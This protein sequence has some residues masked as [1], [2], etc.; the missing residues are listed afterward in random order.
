MYGLACGISIGVGVGITFGVAL[1]NIAIGISTG[2]TP[3]GLMG[4]SWYK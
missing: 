2:F 3:Y 4:R 1:D